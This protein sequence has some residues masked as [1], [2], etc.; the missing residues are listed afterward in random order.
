VALLV[1]AGW[2]LVQNP[3]CIPTGFWWENL[4][5]R[6]H[7]QYPGVGGRIVLKK[8]VERIGTGLIWLRIGTDGWHL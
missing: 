6:H 5:E 2:I 4:K 3:A 1:V 7:L 8:L